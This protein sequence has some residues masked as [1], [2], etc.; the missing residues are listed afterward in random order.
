M[1]TR[2]APPVPPQ[3]T[4]SVDCNRTLGQEFLRQARMSPDKIA[5]TDSLG[6]TLTYRQL[7]L[8]AFVTAH[9][10]SEKVKD[11]TCVGIL[12]PPSAGA[13]V[14]NLA[15]TILGKIAVNLN[16]STG[17][18]ALDFSINECKIWHVITTDKLLQK[19]GLI[20]DRS[21]ILIE[22]IA[23]HISL[24]RQ[25]R[26]WIEAAFAD[27]HA[28]AKIFPGLNK[29]AHCDLSEFGLSIDP[30]KSQADS[31]CAIIF[32]AGS[33]GRPKG[34]VLSHKNILSNIAGVNEAGQIKNGEVVLG[35][36]PFFHS[37]GLT[38]TLWAPLCLGE[39]AVYHYD[40]FDARKIASLCR[41]FQ[42]T[43]LICTP[44]MMG[45]YLRKV[46]TISFKS[47]THC[48]LGGEKLHPALFDLIYNKLHIVPLEGYG[49]A[50]T[51]PVIACNVPGQV[52][53]ARNMSIS[54]TRR[55]TV[56]RPIPGTSIQIRDPETGEVLNPNVSGMIYVKGLQ[57]ML[58][59]LNEPEET[60]LAF[61]DGWFKTG[62]LGK[63]DED[64][65]LTIT[66]RQGQFSKIGGEMVSHLAVEEKLLQLGECAP[67][68]L[69]VVSIPDTARG[70]RL[71][72]LYEKSALCNPRELFTRLI[73]QY[74]GKLWIPKV[75][76]FFAVDK[77]PT[78]ANGKFDLCRLHELA[79]AEA[80]LH[81]C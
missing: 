65:F 18:E 63:L 67:G 80:A 17:Q 49:L 27:E 31:P 23:V 57:T 53:S 81:P 12:L 70:E 44:T 1:L 40:P 68:Q 59:Y 47:L 45:T 37:F 9:Y 25:L 76:D 24:L 74:G 64:G 42:A 34:V 32:T 35:V 48:I 52:M 8:R 10:L 20:P 72:V 58:G 15:V 61:D 79:L 56:G 78:L 55:G 36:I 60:D 14:A 19:T 29:D 11:D 77:L 13:V 22:N 2:E 39:M 66:G 16:Y 75:E 30:G 41:N 73:K 3:A 62:D 71:I 46:P 4:R 50:E 6:M 21:T 38:M 7:L 51:S 69:K 33:T 26:T 28:L 5:V 54:G 43:S